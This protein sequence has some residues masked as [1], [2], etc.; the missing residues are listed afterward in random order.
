MTE[1]DMEKRSALL[2]SAGL[3]PSRIPKHIAI[4]MDGNGRW[5]QNRGEDRVFGHLNGVES[6]R[7]VVEAA[8]QI[9]VR[10]LTLYAFS[11]D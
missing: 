8:L 3:D 11:T 2:S 6:V 5:A 4:I 7:A 10:Y 9:G 1:T